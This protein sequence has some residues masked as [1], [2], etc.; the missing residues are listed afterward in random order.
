MILQH[1]HP[2]MESASQYKYQW[3]KQIQIWG[4][5]CIHLSSLAYSHPSVSL[6]PLL[7]MHFLIF[8]CFL[9]NISSP[10]VI[11][12]AQAG[13][14]MLISGLMINQLLYGFSQET[15]TIKH[16][17]FFVVFLVYVKVWAYTLMS[18]KANKQKW[19]QRTRIQTLSLEH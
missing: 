13:C 1:V 10:S 7:I 4:C 2:H 18:Q 17:S 6:F 9:L 11:Q 19:E 3:R 14:S 12:P 15:A 5:I 8:F 16:P